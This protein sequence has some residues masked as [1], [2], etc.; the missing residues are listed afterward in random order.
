MLT[1][2]MRSPHPNLDRKAC[3]PCSPEEESQL[4]K[5]VIP[6]HSKPISAAMSISILPS[7]RPAPIRRPKLS[8]QTN[9][10]PLLFATHKSSTGIALNT[11]I[12][13]PTVRNTYNNAFNPQRAVSPSAKRQTD[14]LPILPQSAEMFSPLA[15]QST[16]SS[17]SSETSPSSRS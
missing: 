8:L 1:L 4:P 14:D 10:T 17:A 11:A 12:D 13:S 16:T 5:R 6:S 9:T 2:P 7:V 3:V 15:P